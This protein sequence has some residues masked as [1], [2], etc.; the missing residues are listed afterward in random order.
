MIRKE[1]VKSEETARGTASQ[2][3][4]MNIPED[5][6]EEVEFPADPEEKA[7][8]P[9]IPEAFKLPESIPRNLKDLMEVNLVSEEEIQT[10]VARKGYFPKDTPIQNYPEDFINGVLVGA[11][12]QVY[13][14]IKTL[15]ESY[16]I[17]FDK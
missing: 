16:E 1:P 7:G 9:Q 12:K 6:D 15:R 8:K 11:W 2:Y 14:C 10:V 17:P 3:D 4:F 5:T 13:Q